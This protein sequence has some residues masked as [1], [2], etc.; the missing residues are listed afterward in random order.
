M[1]IHQAYLTLG[2]D[3]SATSEEVGCRF[4][5]LVRASHPD[6]KPS[7]EEALANE[8]TRILVEACF[9]IRAKKLDNIG[10]LGSYQDASVDSFAWIDEA[11]RECIDTSFV[12]VVSPVFGLRMMLGAWSMGWG[13]V[14]GFDPSSVQAKKLR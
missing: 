4:R 9:L 2:L 12:C 11:W 5:T 6:G 13:F 14:F 3:A 7:H 1:T 8:K 10:A